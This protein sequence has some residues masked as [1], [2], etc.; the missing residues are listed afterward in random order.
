MYDKDRGEMPVM[1]YKNLYGTYVAKK[2]LTYYEASRQRRHLEDLGIPNF[3]VL[4]ETTSPERVEQMLDAVDEFTAGRGSNIFL[5]TDEA[6]LASSNP[7][8]LDWVSGKKELLRLT[9]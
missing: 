6:S 8:D 4:V 5:F 3:R 2:L 9:D 1:R 7:L